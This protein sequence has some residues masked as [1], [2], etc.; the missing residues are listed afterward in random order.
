MSPVRDKRAPERL[1]AQVAAGDTAVPGE[2]GYP[3]LELGGEHHRCLTAAYLWFLIM[4]SHGARGAT[5]A[6]R[7]EKV[8]DHHGKLPRIGGLLLFYHFLLVLFTVHNSILTAGSVMVYVHSSATG[9]SHVSLPSLIFYVATNAA[10]ILYVIYLFTLMSR[11][12][13]SAIANNIAFNLLSVLFL[14][15][16]HLIGEKSTIGTIADSA[17]N[18]VIAAYFLLSR[19]VRTT[20][21]V[22]RTSGQPVD[23]PDRLSR[24]AHAARQRCLLTV[25]RAGHAEPADLL[26][27]N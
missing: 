3:N 23:M 9:R 19:K 4:Q 26:D 20:F 10:L 15:T 7:P 24:D 16:W 21:V 22:G 17:P 27:A 18:L 1:A 13:K 12:R 25:A 8:A 11:R 14:V 6:D 5:D 2:F